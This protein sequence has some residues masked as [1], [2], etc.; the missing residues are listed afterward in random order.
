MALEYQLSYTAEDI[1]NRLGLVKENEDA[2]KELSNL[3]ENKLDKSNPA[4]IGSLSLNRLAN[5]NIGDKSI[6]IGD[7]TT[8]S[9]KASFAEGCLTE[10]T[11]AQAHAEGDGTK[12]TSLGA[13]AEGGYSTVNGTKHFTTASGTYAHAEGRGTNAT[14]SASHAEGELTNA[15]GIA[16][17][18]EGKETVAESD[19]SHA[20]G[21]LSKALNTSAHAEGYNTKAEGDSSHTEGSNTLASAHSAHAEGKYTKA[22]GEGAHAEGIFGQS[23]GNGTHVEGY[24]PRGV[25]LRKVDGQQGYLMLHQDNTKLPNWLNGY[26]WNAGVESNID[27]NAL[28]LY[29]IGLYDTADKTTL[30]ATITKTYTVQTEEGYDLYAILDTNL[31]SE[32]EAYPDRGFYIY[33][34][35]AIKTGSHAE[36]SSIALGDYSHAEGSITWAAGM[37]HSEGVFTAAMQSGA[38]AEGTRTIARG[39]ASHTEGKYSQALATGSHAEGFHTT[40][41]TDY[42]HVQGKYNEID[43]NNQY[44]HI[45]GGGTS[46][47]DRKN[48]YTLDWNGNAEFSG[49]IIITSPDG[50]AK[51]S[52]FELSTLVSNLNTVVNKLLEDQ[53]D[54]S[55]SNSQLN[56]TT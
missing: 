25:Y 18:A 33:Y 7:R 23:L 38:H 21:F 5:T 41:N 53:I 14:Q 44:A 48:I 36:G 4:G 12:A 43:N 52:L 9:G 42:Q 10:A 49:D 24:G 30:K 26:Y 15:N 56:I 3:I 40:A 54:L 16:S 27:T 28:P 35:K 29:G 45:V 55:V 1:D 17:H 46:E 8:A 34:N 22:T 19:Y 6:A 31:D 50:T 11:A 37:A 32:I 20:E 39:G 13:H 51:I 47:T 2:I